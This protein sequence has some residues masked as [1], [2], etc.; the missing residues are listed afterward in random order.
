MRDQKIVKLEEQVNKL[1]E[2]LNWFHRQ[3]FG[4]KSERLVKNLNQ[5]QLLLEGFEILNTQNTEQTQTVPAHT[6]RKSNRKG[7]DKLSMPDNLP[8]QTTI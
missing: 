3:I 5:D 1:E 7:Q 6:R 2:Q 4:K 8:V